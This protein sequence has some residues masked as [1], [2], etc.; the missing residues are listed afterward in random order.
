VL[1]SA[2]S[3]MSTSSSSAATTDSLTTTS[4]SAPLATGGDGALADTS[5]TVRTGGAGRSPPVLIS[6]L[7]V[8]AMGV[9]PIL[10]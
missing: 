3:A 2:T 9:L 4:A 8:M 1:W 10:I 6:S 5:A 7:F